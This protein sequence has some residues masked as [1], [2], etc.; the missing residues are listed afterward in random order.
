MFKIFCK[1]INKKYIMLSN[2]KTVTEKP[3]DI[4]RQIKGGNV[5]VFPKIH[6]MLCWHLLSAIYFILLV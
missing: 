3:P 4:L 2:V 6:K 1:S 5:T